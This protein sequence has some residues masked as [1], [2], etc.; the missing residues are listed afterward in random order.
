MDFTADKLDKPDFLTLNEIVTL[1]E[2]L[3]TRKCPGVLNICSGIGISVKDA[4]IAFGKKMGFGDISK[5]LDFKDDHSGL[6][7]LVGDR[8]KLDATMNVT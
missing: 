4:S 8:S 7:Y 3:W 1:M 6:P 2:S 5:M